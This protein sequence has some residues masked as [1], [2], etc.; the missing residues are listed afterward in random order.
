MARLYADEDI[1]LRPVLCLRALGHDV[2]TVAERGRCE[3]SDETVLADAQREGRIVLTHN[4]KHFIRLHRESQTHLG[5]ISCSRDE[6]DE[7]LA[8]R[9]HIAL[10]DGTDLAGRHVRINRPC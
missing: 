4:R 2:V 10:T 6:D 9:I 5:I 3:G 1:P 8:H 7:A